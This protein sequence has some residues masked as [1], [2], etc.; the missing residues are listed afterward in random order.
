MK[1][2]GGKDFRKGTWYEMLKAC[3]GFQR[4]NGFCSDLFFGTIS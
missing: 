2:Q 4:I 1:A 3:N